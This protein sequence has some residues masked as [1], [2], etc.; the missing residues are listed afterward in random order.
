MTRVGTSGAIHAIIPVPPPSRSSSVVTPRRPHSARPAGKEEY[1]TESPLSTPSSKWPTIV[2]FPG[3]PPPTGEV[4]QGNDAPLSSMTRAGRGVAAATGMRPATAPISTGGSGAPPPPPAGSVHSSMLYEAWEEGEGG[5]LGGGET[6][7]SAILQSPSQGGGR[8][9]SAPA[10]NAGKMQWKRRY[11]TLE[12]ANVVEGPMSFEVKLSGQ[13]QGGAS[14]NRDHLTWYYSDFLEKSEGDY[15]PAPVN[16][17]KEEVEL[18]ELIKWLNSFIPRSRVDGYPMLVIALDCLNKLASKFAKVEWAENKRLL[19]VMQVLEQRLAVFK[20]EEE[21]RQTEKKLSLRLNTMGCQA[22]FGEAE[23]EEVKTLLAEATRKAGVEKEMFNAKKQ[24]CHSLEVALSNAQRQLK[25]KE[26]EHEKQIK[27]LEANAEY[28]IRIKQDAYN[29]QRIKKVARMMASDNFSTYFRIWKNV[30]SSRL[31]RIRNLRT[32]L[33]HCLGFEVKATFHEWL[34]AAKRQKDLRGKSVYIEGMLRRRAELW[35][36][37]CM[38]KNIEVRYY[39]KLKQR[40]AALRRRVLMNEWGR[41]AFLDL[42]V[43]VRW[44]RVLRDMDDKTYHRLVTL[45]FT[46]LRVNVFES[47]KERSEGRGGALRRQSTVSSRGSAPQS[48]KDVVKM[49]APP[50]ARHQPQPTNQ[51]QARKGSNGLDSAEGGLTMRTGLVESS[52]KRG[53]FNLDA[54]K[55]GFASSAVSGDYPT[56]QDHHAFSRSASRQR[57]IMRPFSN[58][59]RLLGAPSLSRSPP[60]PT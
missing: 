16:E 59:C 32:G 54:I 21:L 7:F 28:K 17:G 5:H 35:V 38:V 49:M 50:K 4:L 12:D 33:I 43:N 55:G 34:K 2:G 15:T 57:Y 3:I 52:V 46:S 42:C 8:E 31:D 25:W 48:P 40:Q 27:Q 13:G 60:R 19:E 14:H 36:V 29:Q 30:W 1:R 9:G 23:L 53:S 11:Y 22:S 56:L 37:G 41:R 24:E 6:K 58:L 26:I 10:E 51:R 18:E 20:E 39:E 44:G 47:L 45:S